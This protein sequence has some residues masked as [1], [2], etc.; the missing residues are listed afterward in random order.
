L[1]YVDLKTRCD[2]DEYCIENGEF[3]TMMNDDENGKLRGE[4]LY[5]AAC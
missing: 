5:S 4:G 1:I 3:C 2:E